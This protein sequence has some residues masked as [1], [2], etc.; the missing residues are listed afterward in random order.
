MENFYNTQSE[1]KSYTDFMVEDKITETEGGNKRYYF[2]VSEPHTYR[3]FTLEVGKTTFN[4]YEEGDYL[5]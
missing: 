5:D 2:I 3:L 1:I 4:N